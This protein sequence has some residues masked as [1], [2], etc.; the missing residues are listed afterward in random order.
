MKAFFQM[1]GFSMFPV[2]LCGTAALLVALY[3]AGRPQKHLIV[4]SERLGWAELF[5]A[6]SGMLSNVAVTLWAVSQS[7]HRGDGFS[8][9]LVTGLYESSAP[10]IMGFSFL[11]LVHLS[12]AIAGYRLAKR[13]P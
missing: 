7:E 1:G 9:M 11:A 5:F 4:L 8:R 2:L 13:E 12:L 3:A 6:L 10:G